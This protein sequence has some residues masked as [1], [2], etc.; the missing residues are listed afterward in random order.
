MVTKAHALDAIDVQEHELLILVG[1]G[2]PGGLPLNKRAIE[3]RHGD[4][5]V[6]VMTKTTAITKAKGGATIDHIIAVKHGD[7]LAL[8]H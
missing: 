2:H 3:H 7:G 1:R 8:G 5:L 4:G 6:F